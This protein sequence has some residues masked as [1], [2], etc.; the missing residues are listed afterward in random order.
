MINKAKLSEL[1]AEYMKHFPEQWKNEVFKWEAIK[2]FHDNWDIDAED[3]IDMFMRATDKTYSLLA[4]ANSFPRGMIRSFATY[5]PQTV[6]QMFIDLFDESKPVTE[7]IDKFRKSSDELRAKHDDI[8]QSHYQTE[9]AI[10]T[11]LWLMYPDKYYIYKY[12]EVKAF[13]TELESDFIPKKGKALANVEGSFKLYD[14]V[15]EILKTDVALNEMLN[16]ALT[17][18]CYSDPERI[19]LTIDIEFFVSRYYKKDEVDDSAWFPSDYSPNFTVE[20]WKNML[21]DSS[22]FNTNNL[23]IMKRML[24]FGGEATCTQLSNKYGKTKNFYNAGSSSLGK[25][26]AEKTGCPVYEGSEINSKYWPILYVGRG[27]DKEQDGSW[28]WKLRSELKEALESIDLSG[29]KLFAD[30]GEE[31]MANYWWLNANPKI[32]SFADIAIGEDQEYTLYNDNGNKRRI[33]Q[34]FLDVKVGDIVIGYESNP[35]KQ[36]VAIVEIIRAND[37]KTIGF[38]KTEGLANPIDY[39]A[40]KEASELAQMECFTNP[41]GSLFKLTKSEFDYIMDVVRENNPVTP[42]NAL[43]TYTK[44]DFLEAVYVSEDKYDSLVSLL[45]NKKNLILQGA[46]GVGKTFAAKRLAYSMMGVKD[47]DRIELIQF[48]QNYSYEDFMMGYKPN[49]TG[50]KL[51]YGVFYQFC[52]KAANQPQKDFFFIID[53]I[54]RGNLSKI[55]GELLMLIEKA[56]R[57]KQAKLAYNGMKFA[58]PEN[59]YIIGMMNTADR[60]LAMIDYALRRRFC[61]YDMTPGFDTDGFRAHQKKIGSPK[62]DKIIEVIKDLNR[63]IIEDNSLGKGFCIGHSYF[64]EHEND[65]DDSWVD[66]VVEYD[67]I[68]TLCE[69]WFDDTDKFDKWVGILRGALK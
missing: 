38:R 4:S 53:E 1:I 12:S 14:E 29:V 47:E 44:K 50:F 60:S 18:T 21:Q 39:S 40:L 49:D 19:T 7:R 51:K 28:I 54:N 11:Y 10:T 25:R 42:S 63:E 26:I 37:G 9:N 68:P 23:Q 45:K 13:A 41:Q 36:V 46:P 43:N 69:Y 66:E 65:T 55:F 62:L 17:E 48:H 5:E 34:N 32:W 27:A 31:G 24:D 6:R 64:C 8:W 15:R 61:F 3:F 2:I 58:V 59:L 56:Y 67:I 52:Q 33:F 22:I 35:V 20:D 16:N 57:G 30:D